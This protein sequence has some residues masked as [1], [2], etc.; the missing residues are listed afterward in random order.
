MSRIV[1][2]SNASHRKNV[3]SHFVNYQQMPGLVT[4]TA[5]SQA[6]GG[7]K[8]HKKR[9]SN[10]KTGGFALAPIIAGASAVHVG[11]EKLKPFSRL[12]KA[13]EDHVPD[14]KK[15]NLLYKI[16]HT[17]TG[18]GKSVGYGKKKK[19]RTTKKK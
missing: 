2:S 17:I 4:G 8:R 15:N 1:D 14:S 9:K 13:L 3:R 7:G 5:P 19:K 18:L 10:K 6:G 11:L 12:N 16:A